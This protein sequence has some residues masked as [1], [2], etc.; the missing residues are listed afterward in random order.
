MHLK[1]G[2]IGKPKNKNLSHFWNKKNMLQPLTWT[3]S[4]VFVFFNIKDKTQTQNN[5]NTRKQEDWDWKGRLE[6]G[7]W[8]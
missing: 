8:K 5:K 3:K 2:K 4:K 7:I 6:D 1:K